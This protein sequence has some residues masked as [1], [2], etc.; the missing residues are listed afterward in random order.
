MYITIIS[1]ILAF[2][3]M[4][5]GL[6]WS[7]TGTAYVTN[8]APATLVVRS[9][10]VSYTQ[11]ETPPSVVV[12]A[13]L[14]YDTGVSGR[15]KSWWI[16]PKIINGYG[17]YSE[18]PGMSLYRKSQSYKKGSR[19]KSIGLDLVL[20]VP[21]SLFADA[22]VFMCNMKAE[23]LRNQGKSNAWIFSQDRMVNFEVR[24]DYDVD[25]WGAGSNNPILEGGGYKEITVW[26][27]RFTGPKV[28]T[29]NGKLAVP[30]KV[31]K[32][33]MQVKA[34]APPSGICR[35]DT[36]TAISTNKSNATIKYRFVHDSG[37][38]SKVFTTK[39]KANRIAVV[40]HQWD[41]PNGPGKEQGWVRI[42]GVSPKFMSNKGSYSMNCHAKGAGGL[43]G[44]SGA[45]NP[46]FSGTL[47]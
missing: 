1:G 28:P 19:P 2:A 9:N 45:G 39:T 14:E 6:A 27:S 13:R 37:K 32:A 38:K 7:D 41:I 35:I 30:T 21:G 5:P 24:V 20:P 44:K 12:F 23:H 26:C 15:I 34:I 4:L 10:G 22:A 3:A 36:V 33:T 18:L 25:A 42:E 43:S 31:I 46:G 17:I 47:R 29:V 40:R 11:L 8:V 16:Q